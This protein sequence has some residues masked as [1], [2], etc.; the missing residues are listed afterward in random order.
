[1]LQDQGPVDQGERN[2][3]AAQAA[4]H[5]LWES[6]EIERSHYCTRNRPYFTQ[7]ALDSRSFQTRL[8]LWQGFAQLSSGL[9]REP[10]RQ[11]GN[12]GEN[13]HVR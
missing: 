7:G 1:M 13:G 6:N 3:R 4:L 10:F 8:N 5:Q 12:G 9:G 11:N 2:L